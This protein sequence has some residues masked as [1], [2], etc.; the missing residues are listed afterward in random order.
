M[1]DGYMYTHCP[2]PAR[3]RRKIAPRSRAAL[4]RRSLT[5]SQTRSSSQWGLTADRGERLRQHQSSAAAAH[6]SHP[7]LFHH[8]CT[9]PIMF[10]TRSST[11]H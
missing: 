7:Q 11:S 4:T 8:G 5:P 9:Y 6:Q 10:P 3:P 1:T 2:R